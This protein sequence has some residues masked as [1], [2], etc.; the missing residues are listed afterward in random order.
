MSSQDRRLG[1]GRCRSLEL[2]LL[3]L[4][5]LMVVVVLLLLMVH[6]WG[7]AIGVMRETMTPL[8]CLVNGPQ[9]EG[10]PEVVG[11]RTLWTA[12]PHASEG[13]YLVLGVL[14]REGGM[15]GVG[16]AEYAAEGGG[17]GTGQGAHGRDGGGGTVL[18]KGPLG[19]D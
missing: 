5:I 7:G 4:L 12:G 15:G 2:L 19:V 13:L 1:L 10:L 8:W 11:A 6:P 9:G 16:G 3:L 17:L 14:V 18:V